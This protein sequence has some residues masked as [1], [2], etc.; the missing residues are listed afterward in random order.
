M[1]SP[2]SNIHRT[3]HDVTIDAPP[4]TVYAIVSDATRWPLYFAPT[5]HVDREE[6]DASAERLHIWALA[7]GEIK[8]WTSRRDLDPEHRTIVFRQEKSTPPVL[9][10]IG[11]WTVTGA[12]DGT[13]LI[14]DHEFTA[15]G[16]AG[17]AWLT[18]ATEDNSTT[19]LANIKS[20]A[21][22]WRRRDELTTTFEDSV[23]IAAPIEV[24]YDFLYRADAWPMRLP[25]VSRL[26]LTED[27]PNV[28]RMTMD[29][30][31]KDGSTHTTESVRIC[32]PY[33]RIPY[34][35]LVPPSLM[36]AHTGEWTLHDTGDGV[37]ATSQ[38]SVVIEERAITSVLGPDATG[39]SAVAFAHSAL[40][41]NSSA[42]L[43]LAKEFAEAGR[44]R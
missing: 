20:L 14:L 21:E 7:N 16:A 1:S 23:L 40:S 27:E 11:T 30:Q 42:T 15:E 2:S 44:G 13:R 38:H 26:D 25:H 39:A 8:S 9:S 28:Q 34:K 10:M 6:L 35:Q 3:R 24:V 32:F 5:L 17:V 36:A 19:E 31:G 18:Q 22:Q 29:T 41:T 12:G 43:N 33:T 4:D 37:L